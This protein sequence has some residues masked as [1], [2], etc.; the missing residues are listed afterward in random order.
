MSEL[1]AAVC[2]IAPTARRRWFWAAWW[3]KAPGRDPFV[4]P[5]AA[6]GGASSREAALVAAQ[7]AAGRSLV[8]IEPRWARAVSRVLRE[9]PPWTARDVEDFAS[10]GAPRPRSAPPI[11]SLWT[12]LGVR[13]DATLVELKQAY[14]RRALET[15]PDHGGDPE[16]FR[17]L[18]AAYEKARR[19][20]KATKR[21]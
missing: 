9:L 21:S 17:A 19:R 7:K 1:A 11:A 13:S 3:T 4:R 10:G 5:D 8:E 2:S 15:H 20:R 14:H 6:S 18:R 16:A 12:L